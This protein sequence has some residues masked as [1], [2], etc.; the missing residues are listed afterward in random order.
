MTK[1]DGKKYV[2]H[3]NVK[4]VMTQ[5]RFSAW[6]RQKN[7]RAMVGKVK[8]GYEN[9]LAMYLQEKLGR[10]GKIS[11]MS[12][13]VGGTALRKAWKKMPSW[14]GKFLREVNKLYVDKGTKI[15]AKKAFD[16]LNS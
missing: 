7:S 15:T 14:A 8:S 3:E 9:P 6:L 4:T 10:P 13:F 11:V 5:A 12:T 16:I 2:T 1:R